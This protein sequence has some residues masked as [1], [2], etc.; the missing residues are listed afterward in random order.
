MFCS[1]ILPVLL[2]VP[3]FSLASPLHV[4]NPISL[5]VSAR[6]NRTGTANLA[7]HD[8][9]RARFLKERAKGKKDTDA[10]LTRRQASFPV[11]NEG[12]TYTA[13]VGVGSPATTYDLIIDTG[14]SNTWVGATQSYVQTSTGSTTGRIVSVSYGP[15]GSGVGFVGLEFIDR[16]TLSPELVI[17]NQSIGVA[18]ESGGFDGVD[19]ILGIGPA[20][21]TQG[22]VQGAG[23]IPTV[24]DNLFA[25]KTIPTE[26]IGVFFEPS[27]LDTLDPVTSGELTFGGINQT[28]ITSDVAFTPITTTSPAS[29]FWGID[30]SVS[31]GSTT[32]METT[33]GIVDTG[34]TLVL[35]PSD[36]FARYVTA[37]GAVNDA[38]TGLLRIT[39]A[40][41][42]SLQP[43]N[44]VVGNN[45]FTLSP[46]A[47]LWPR[48]LNTAIG[49][50]AR[51][52]YLIVADFGEP[53]GGGF[54]FVNGFAFLQ[55]FYSVYDT[56]NSRVGL[57]PTEFT[58]ATTN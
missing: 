51:S 25:Q 18:V 8:Q 12:V 42:A 57:A 49:G 11:H 19:G 16:V 21:L 36:A 22:T 6:I 52:I 39:S 24:T 41:F 7:L 33:A 31:Y 13:H 47:Q 3:L 40:Q 2:L 43:L 28:R 55:R 1:T 32:I 44:F 27:T 34:T 56:T 58:T 23:T 54:D 46:N 14:S 53:S 17:S 26:S 50:Q 45:T 29:Q 4:A 30:Q 10:S 20:A 48:S 15:D 38:A 35:L 5:S 37:T 9:A